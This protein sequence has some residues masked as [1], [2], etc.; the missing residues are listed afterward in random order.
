M[1]ST[2][3]YSDKSFLWIVLM[4]KMNYLFIVSNLEALYRFLPYSVIHDY[5]YMTLY[6]MM[7]LYYVH[8]FQNWNQRSRTSWNTEHKISK[9]C[10]KRPH[11]RRPKNGFQDQLSLNAGQTYCRILQFFWSSLSYHLSSRYLFCHFWV[12]CLHWFYYSKDR[13]YFNQNV[14]DDP[15]KKMNTHT[16]CFC[17]FIRKSYAFVNLNE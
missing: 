12:A 2:L 10:V 3:L 13:E 4:K 9:T 8:V 1:R 11:S 5:T 6:F 16:F 17:S 14:P 7:T 15:I